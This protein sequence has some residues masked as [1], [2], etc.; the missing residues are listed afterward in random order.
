MD[1]NSAYPS[2]YIKYTDLQGEEV[3]VIMSGITM[4]DFNDDTRPVLSFIGKKKG[5]VLN[6]TNANM[7]TTLYGEETDVWIGKKILL[8]TAWVDYAGKQMQTVRVR[9]IVPGAAVALPVPATIP[10]VAEMTPEE[11]AAGLDAV[12]MTPLDSDIPF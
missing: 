1:I 8:V 3:E 5:L 4:A 9:P 2:K 11:I 12:P 10:P 6:K 7:I